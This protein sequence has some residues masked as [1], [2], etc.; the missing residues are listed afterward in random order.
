MTTFN[1]GDF[2]NQCQTPELVQW[3][4]AL[5]PSIEQRLQPDSQRNF[6][7]WLAA[8][9]ALS[10]IS[11][12]VVDLNK[13]A[14]TTTTVDPLP[15]V[16]AVRA[17]LLKLIPW[18]KGPFNLHGIYLDCE[19][20]CDWKWQRLA[21]HID[22]AGKTVLD[23]GSG[24]GYYSLRMLGAGARQVIGLDTSLL[25]CTQYQA[26]NRFTREHRATVLP[27]GVEILENHPFEFE[28]IFSMGVLYHRRQ[29][30]DHLKLLHNSLCDDGELILETLILHGHTVETLIPQDRYANMRNVWSVPSLPALMQQLETAGFC[31]A[32]CIDITRTTTSEQRATEW[33]PFNS[34]SNALDSEDNTL[35]VEGHPGPLRAV[36]VAKK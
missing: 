21:N 8:L 29:P 22:L 2:R 25:F 16:T 28:T 19:W 1:I 7:G 35:T 27:A 34:L 31:S 3:L 11:S 24:N 36:I 5:M 20:R 17:N 15:D 4:D 13:D 23:V 9:D 14:I 18:R 32:R 6:P 30:V 26:V 33:M 10:G 12:A